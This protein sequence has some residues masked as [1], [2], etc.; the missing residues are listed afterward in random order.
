MY[1]ETVSHQVAG[2]MLWSSTRSDE[3]L[4]GRIL[5]DGCMDLIWSAHGG[6]L[7]AGPDTAAYLD[8]GPPGARYFGLRFAPGAGPAVLG[9]PASELRDRRVPLS[10]VWASSLVREFEERVATTRQPGRLLESIARD[11]LRDHGGPDPLAAL[12]VEH[13]AA[14]DDVAVTAAQLGLGPR[15][16]HRR[17]QALFGY[18]PKML[19]RILRMQRALALARSGVP[20]AEVA[21]RSGYADQPHLSRDVRALAGV[22]L[23]VLVGAR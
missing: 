2:A 16:L 5:P 11:R 8:D 14:G 22:P 10:A 7:V 9:M 18:G 4:P 20:A 17:C 1:Q 21:V 3:S 12:V 23:G 15:Q 19:T 13:I 6:L